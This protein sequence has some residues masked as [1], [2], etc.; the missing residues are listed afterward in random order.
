MS[1]RRGWKRWVEDSSRDWQIKGLT[2]D[3]FAN[4]EGSRCTVAS[5]PSLVLYFKMIVS[6]KAKLGH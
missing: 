3:F 4:D 1:D 6:R 5:E 2:N